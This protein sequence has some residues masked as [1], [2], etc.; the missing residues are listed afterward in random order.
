M[1][2]PSW[3]NVPEWVQYIAMDGDGDQWGFSKEPYQDRRMSIWDADG[4]DVQIIYLGTR[5][6]DWKSTLEQRPIHETRD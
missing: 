2:K 1:M 6:P 5:L 4:D 3:D